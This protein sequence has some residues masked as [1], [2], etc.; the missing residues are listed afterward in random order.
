MHAKACLVGKLEN[1]DDAEI[2]PCCNNFV[3]K[4]NM[5]INCNDK[6]LEFLGSAYPLFFKMTIYVI[7]FIL[8]LFFFGGSMRIIISNWNC[9]GDS[10]VRFFGY[11]VIMDQ[12]KEKE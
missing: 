2:C 6:D 9:E 8:I 5:D 10:C 11:F 7:V 4:G 12:S 1:T 3:N